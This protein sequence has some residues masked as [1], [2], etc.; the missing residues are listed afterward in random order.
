M[1]APASLEQIL[2]DAI[3]E[4]IR[5]ELE[6]LRVEIERLRGDRATLVALPE[7]ARRLGVDVRTVQRWAKDG[8]LKV[9]EVGGKRMVRLPD[10]LGGGSVPGP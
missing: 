6:R 2:A 1:A 8:R 7:A 5:P 9:E 4:R 3:L 10:G